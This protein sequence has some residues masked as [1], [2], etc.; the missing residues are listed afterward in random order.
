MMFPYPSGNLHIG[1]WYN[2]ARADVFSRFKR[3]SGFN[4]LSP[5]GFDAFGLPAE[6][7]AIKHGIHPKDW[8]YKNIKAMTAQLESMGN[9]YDWSRKIITADLE[10]YKW[11]QWMFLQFIKMDWL[12]KKNAPA[13]WCP[14]CHT[15]LANEQVVN[16]QCERCEAQVVKREIEQWLLKLP[17]MRENY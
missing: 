11:T 12:I 10:Y 7:A 14:K 13:N 1:H 15:V 3:M 2:F 5:I 9:M 16:G 17:I 4:V 8:T 6:N